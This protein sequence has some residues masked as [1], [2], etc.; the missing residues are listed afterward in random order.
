[1]KEL[2]RK[3]LIEEKNLERIK[4]NEVDV[5][6]MVPHIVKYIKGEYGKKLKVKSIK[7][8]VFFGSDSYRGLCTEIVVFVEDESINAAE[9]K[10]QL[11][12]IIKNYFGIDMSLYGS[13]LDITVFE[14]TWKKV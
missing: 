1:M 3:I 14:K 5:P 7:R 2:I 6:K 9:L 13:C 8:G 12:E 10:Y 11:R 4:K